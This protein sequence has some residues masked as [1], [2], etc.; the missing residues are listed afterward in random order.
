MTVN[1]GGLG[2]CV[3]GWS[4]R[5][6]RSAPADIDRNSSFLPMPRISGNPAFTLGR[7]VTVASRAG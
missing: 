3:V 7:H 2:C 1:Y 5:P 6:H 4:E